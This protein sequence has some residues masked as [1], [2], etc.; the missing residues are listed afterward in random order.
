MEKIKCQLCQNEFN[1]KQMGMH[2]TRTHKITYDEYATMYWETLPN[3]SPCKVCGTICTGTY[4][5]M[6]CQKTGVSSKLKGIKQPPR[7]KEHCE[8]I[9][10]AAKE[11]LKD[12]TKHPWLGRNHSDETIKKISKSCKE[13]Y[14]D[15]THQPRLGKRFTDESKQKL[16][17]SQS[18]FYETHDSPFKGKTHTPESI[19]KI[20]EN[21]P[22]NKLEKRVADWFDARGIGYTFQFFINSDG[23]CKSYDFKLKGSKTIVE[24]NGDYWHGGSGIE[25]HVFNVDVNIENDKLKKKMAEDLGYHVITIWEHDI[26]NDITIL[27]ST[28]NLT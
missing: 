13:K 15:A 25:K 4:C 7:T 9:S 28:L 27:E 20:F 24:I 8:K 2:V 12:K 18:K 17:K 3:Y 10:K 21:K 19:R 1:P 23:I 5:S 14:K 26:K 16:S 6:D 22:M 11:R